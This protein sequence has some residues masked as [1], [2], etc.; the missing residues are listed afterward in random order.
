MSIRNIS[1]MTGNDR[2]EGYKLNVLTEKDLDRVAALEQLC[3]SC[4]MSRENLKAFLL[5]ENGCGFVYYGTGNGDDLP[6]AYGG[7]MCVLDEAQI[8]NI[9]THPDHRGRGLGKSITERLIDEARERGIAFI[10]LEVRRSNTVAR[11]LYSSLGFTEVGVLKNYYKRPIE[12]GLIMKLEIS[13]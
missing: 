9:A 12:D 7:M 2:I 1:E 13:S 8:L 4:P 10:T 5:G 11:G 3:F 6:C